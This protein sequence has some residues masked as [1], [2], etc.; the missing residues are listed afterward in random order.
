MNIIERSQ[1]RISLTPWQ[2]EQLLS[3]LRAVERPYHGLGHIAYMLTLFEDYVLTSPQV[4]DSDALMI[5]RA[6]WFHDYIYDATKKDNEWQSALQGSDMLGLVGEV[7]DR[8]V[9]AIMATMTHA[10]DDP[11]IQLLIDLDLA[12]L[13][14]PRAKYEWYMRG[15]RAEYSWVPHELYYSEEGRQKVLRS[16]IDREELCPELSLLMHGDRHV[17][18]DLA[19]ENMAWEITQL[20]QGI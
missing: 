2:L 10:T 8:F 3:A 16:F 12:I 15:V 17:L 18:R 11:A 13:A 14:A 1:A 5:E 19:R 20:R 9:S 7:K 6:I 4:D